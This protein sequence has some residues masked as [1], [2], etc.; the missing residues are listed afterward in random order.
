MPMLCP[1][2]TL[3]VVSRQ[4]R[5]GAAESRC[6][7]PPSFTSTPEIPVPATP[8]VPCRGLCLVSIERARGALA[9]TA[10]PGP[11]PLS[12][13]PPTPTW[14]KARCELPRAWAGL[15]FGPAC[16]CSPA[17]PP[18]RPA[19]PPTPI[20]PS[21]WVRPPALQIRPV[22]FFFCSVNF[23][24]SKELAELQKTPKHHAFNN[25]R[26]VHRIKMV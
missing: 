21:P 1:E 18:S 24:F 12:A 16:P 3:A 6:L 23:L 25:F 15:D 5:P 9:L 13:S 19:R 10:P 2:S 8:V 14:A 7:R 26:T 11:A 4:I 20:G 22:M 17:S